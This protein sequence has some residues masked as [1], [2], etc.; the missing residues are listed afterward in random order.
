MSSTT[1]SANTVVKKEFATIAFALGEQPVN[2]LK[3]FIKRKGET[4][5]NNIPFEL[6]FS[7]GFIRSVFCAKLRRQN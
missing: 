4:S 7:D 2:S 1:R 6:S 5:G 3:N